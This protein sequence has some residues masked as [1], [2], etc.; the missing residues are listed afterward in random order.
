MNKRAKIRLV[1]MVGA[2]L[3]VSAAIWAAEKLK[4]E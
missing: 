4:G 3:V 1:I 2:L